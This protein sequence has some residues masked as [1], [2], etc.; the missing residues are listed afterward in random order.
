MPTPHQLCD[1]KLATSQSQVLQVNWNNFRPAFP[2]GLLWAPA[3]IIREQNIKEHAFKRTEHYTHSEKSLK[4]P[5]QA[6]ASVPLSSSTLVIL[7][8]GMKTYLQ[9]LQALIKLQIYLM[10]LYQE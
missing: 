4:A 1:P 7:K 9:L 5:L 6:T 10:L 3:G 2:W 8:F